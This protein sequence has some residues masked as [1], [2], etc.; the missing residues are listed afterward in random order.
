MKAYF[1]IVLILISSCFQ[2]ILHDY[3]MEDDPIFKA[4]IYNRNW[5]IDRFNVVYSA[6]KPQSCV[7]TS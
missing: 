2:S 1:I 3:V 5:L 7:D 6:E 4:I